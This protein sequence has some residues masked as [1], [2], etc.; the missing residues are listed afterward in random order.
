[1]FD[2]EDF[3][4]EC[5]SKARHI[6]NYIA[7]HIDSGDHEGGV[8]LKLEDA[9]ADAYAHMMQLNPDANSHNCSAEVMVS[10]ED[11]HDVQKIMLKLLKKQY[12]EG[13]M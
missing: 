11:M 4:E 12:E 3:N 13:M 8:T 9:S 7:R 2:Q 1:M 6:I 10:I 5:Y